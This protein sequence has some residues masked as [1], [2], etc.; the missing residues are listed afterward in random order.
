MSKEPV[1]LKAIDNRIRN[2][3][4]LVAGLLLRDRP[5][6]RV[7]KLEALIGIRKGTLAVFFPQRSNEARKRAPP[8]KPR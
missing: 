6:P 5:P 2:L 7:D 8:S 3:E 1:D 4:I